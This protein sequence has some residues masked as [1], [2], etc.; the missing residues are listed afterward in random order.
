MC[1]IKVWWS[2]TSNNY[3]GCPLLNKRYNTGGRGRTHILLMLTHY[4]RQ[5][6]Q[7]N[8][9]YSTGLCT[10]KKHRY[11]F[12]YRRAHPPP[13]VYVLNSTNCRTICTQDHVY[14]IKK[15]RKIKGYVQTKMQ[16]QRYENIYTLVNRY[17]FRNITVQY[18]TVKNIRLQNTPH[19]AQEYMSNCAIVMCCV[20]FQRKDIGKLTCK[21]N[22]CT[23]YYRVYTVHLR[24]TLQCA[25]TRNL[26]SLV[27]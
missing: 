13:L 9:H 17:K 12:M 7:V 6:Q 10:L 4:S 21:H 18:K 2:S 8:V 15:Y 22:A 16:V 20:R 19:G 14:L 26:C 3:D 5:V 23:L 1:E 27:L 25:V 24:Y 11:R